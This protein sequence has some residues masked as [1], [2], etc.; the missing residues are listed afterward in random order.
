LP[1]ISNGS[2][3]LSNKNRT[4]GSFARYVCNEGYTLMGTSLLRCTSD[5]SANETWS[6]IPPNCTGK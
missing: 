2:L 6:N 4:L 5:L 1:N 3:T